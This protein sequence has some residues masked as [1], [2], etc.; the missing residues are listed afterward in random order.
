MI[1]LKLLLCAEDVIRDHDSNKISAINIH[2]G[3][4]ADGYPLL[5][6]FAM[7]AMFERDLNADAARHKVRFEI[8]LGDTQLGGG[9]GEIDFEDKKR[10]RMFVKFP[11]IVV[12]TPGTMSVR[13]YLGEERIGEYLFDGE[14]RQPTLPEITSA[15]ATDA[16]P[17]AATEP[18]PAALNV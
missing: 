17:N 5:M 12:P 4:I 11:G 14:R 3:F 1:T 7:V 13:L 8:Q 15:P 2:E 9:A 10:T 18:P 6:K 16:S